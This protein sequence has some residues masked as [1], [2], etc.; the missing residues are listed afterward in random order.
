MK[1]LR[2]WFIRLVVL[3]V[4]IG[5]L[6]R[7]WVPN[8]FLLLGLTSAGTGLVYFAVMFPLTL[9]YPLGQYVRPRLFPLRARV[10]RALRANSTV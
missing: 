4:A 1:P 6:A 2:P 8:S 9:R 7:I 10:F 5:A 3:V